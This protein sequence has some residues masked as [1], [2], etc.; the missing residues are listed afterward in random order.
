MDSANK[1]VYTL[2]HSSRS[3]DEFVS[4]LKKYGVKVVIDVRRFPTSKRLPHFRREVLE[5]VTPMLTVKRYAFDVELLTA[6][7]ARGYRVAEVPALYPIKL[8]NGFK[9]RE[10]FRMLLDLLAVTYRHRIRK[11]YSRKG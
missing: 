3:L 1:V 2:G 11:Q 4:I 5:E 9:F 10:L 8:C 7:M 6:I